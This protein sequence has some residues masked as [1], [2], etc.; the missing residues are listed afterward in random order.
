MYDPAQIT[1]DLEAAQPRPGAVALL[2]NGRVIVHDLLADLDE[3]EFAALA[4]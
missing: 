1:G 4:T 3:T 2:D